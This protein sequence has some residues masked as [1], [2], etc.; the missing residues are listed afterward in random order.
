MIVVFGSINLD[1]IFA[2]PAIPR[3]GETLLGPQ[4]R[5]EPGGKGAN[6]AVAAARDGAAVALAGA[7]GRDALADDALA[8]LRRAGVDLTRVAVTGAATGCAAIAVDPQGRNAIAV[9]SG[10]NLLGR[11][12]QIEDALL[13]PQNTLLL[14]MECDPA[15]TATLIRRA[16]AAGSRILLNL[17]PA[18]GLAPDALRMVDLLVANESEAAWL[19]AQLGGGADAASL[20]AS[21][22]TAVIRTLGEHGAEAATDEGVLAVPAHAVAAID[23]TAAGDCFVG[24]LAAGIDRGMALADAL[25]RA[26]VAAALACTRHGSQGSLPLAAE[27][28]AA[29]QRGERERR[30]AL[31]S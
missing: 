26:A 7:V 25:R 20:A 1:L 11:A 18:A 15:E 30:P 23:T 27:T 14:Q 9:G 21:L 2:L 28:D 10:A 22:G 29:M 3:A 5:I 12:A 8:L 4:V 13:G 16:R 24:V 17:A 31:G 19:A 6:Q